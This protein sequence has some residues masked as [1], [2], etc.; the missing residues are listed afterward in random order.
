MGGLLGTPLSCSLVF[1]QLQIQS[2]FNCGVT[3][4]NLYKRDL[5]VSKSLCDFVQD[6]E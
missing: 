3:D 1:R 5:Q 4:V 6:I 2:F